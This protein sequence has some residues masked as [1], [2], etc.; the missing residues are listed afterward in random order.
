MKNFR[1][2]FIHEEFIEPDLTLIYPGGNFKGLW[3]GQFRNQYEKRLNK[4]LPKGYRNRVPSEIQS[5]R[6]IKKG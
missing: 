1:A 2:E 3:D 6:N 5:K 4:T